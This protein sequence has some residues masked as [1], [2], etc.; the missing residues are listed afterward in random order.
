MPLCLGGLRLYIVRCLSMQRGLHKMETPGNANDLSK[1]LG[2]QQTF[3][4]VCVVSLTCELS[5]VKRRGIHDAV[6]TE[7][8]GFLLA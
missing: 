1:H 2:Q 4:G 8:N 6:I 7:R 3:L 5:Q